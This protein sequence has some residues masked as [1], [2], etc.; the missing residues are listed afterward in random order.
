MFLDLASRY[1]SAYTLAR[2][3]FP[4][5]NTDTVR[6]R[7]R[8]CGIDP[9]FFRKFRM[10]DLAQKL[11]HRTV[12]AMM[13]AMEKE[14]GQDVGAIAKAM[15]VSLE[16]AVSTLRTNGNAAL[17]R[18]SM[19]KIRNKNNRYQGGNT[20]EELDFDDDDLEERERMTLEAS[21]GPDYKRD[22]V[23]GQIYEK[24]LRGWEIDPAE[25]TTSPNRF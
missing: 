18:D 5:L 1:M 10:I 7:L 11:G 15:G 17:Y 2:G 4:E 25:K 8:R 13:R 6:M 3:E 21:T 14:H 23:W 19:H 16:I 24:H 12:K 20:E 9:T 22:Q